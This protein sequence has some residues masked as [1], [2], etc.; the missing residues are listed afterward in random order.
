MGMDKISLLKEEIVRAAAPICQELGIEVV[1]LNVRPFND[2]LTIQIFADRPMGGIGIE[3]CTRLNRRLDKVLYE[4]M[5]LGDHYTL[6]VSSP[7]LDRDLYGYKDLRRIIGRQVQVFFKEP[8]RGKHEVSGILKAVREADIIV[9]V[10]KEEW[11]I[12]MGSIEKSK[13]II[14]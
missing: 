5:K 8:Q 14:I 7:G 12:P 1:E 6:E 11:T 3:E 4:E 2:G 9:E 10:R 13:Q